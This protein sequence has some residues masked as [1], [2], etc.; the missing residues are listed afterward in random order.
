[1]TQDYYGTKKVTAW[2]APREGAPGYG[3]KYED[4]YISWSPKEQFE[5]AYQPM[6]AL[7][8]GHAVEAMKAG[9]KVRR[10]GWNGKG[11][12]LSLVSEMEWSTVSRHLGGT[13]V[14]AEYLPWIGM[15][16]ADNHFVPWLASQMDMLAD[17]WQVIE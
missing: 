6:D 11:M 1:M 7:S 8:F 13:A 5:A 9:E 2:E 16:T 14:G 17:D 4:G 12:W 15:K 10:A 3:V